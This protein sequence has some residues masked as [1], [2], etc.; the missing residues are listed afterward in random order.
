MYE[1]ANVQRESIFRETY[2][3]HTDGLKCIKG[4][5]EVQRMAIETNRLDDTKNASRKVEN[6]AS[7]P[8][9]I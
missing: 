6:R 2:L 1:G 8:G 9:I 4:D 3:M 7:R 5:Q